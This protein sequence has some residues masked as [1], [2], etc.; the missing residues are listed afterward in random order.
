MYFPPCIW[1]TGSS[2]T[3]LTFLS[4]SVEQNMNRKCDLNYNGTSSCSSTQ[5]R[6]SQLLF[7][8]LNARKFIVKW[9]Y[10]WNDVKTTLF[11]KFCNNVATGFNL[12]LT[13]GFYCFRCCS[14]KFNNLCNIDSSRGISCSYLPGNIHVSKLKDYFNVYCFTMSRN[15]LYTIKLILSLWF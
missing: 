8:R 10:G 13:Q 5:L 9:I 3:F 15:K 7:D 11:S 1:H 6:F 14:I 4:C 12:L 2:I